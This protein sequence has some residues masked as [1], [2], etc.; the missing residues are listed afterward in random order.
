[1]D[2]Q[3]SGKL[4]LVSGSTAGIGLAI[5]SIL[6]GEG[7]TVI[8]NGRSE[9]RVSEAIEKIRGKH[10]RAKLEALVADLSTVEAVKRAAGTFPH[11]DVS[12]K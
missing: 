11:V 4:A 8:I 12:D 9:K 5:G 1:M 10:P 7:A 3:L 2:L 6:A